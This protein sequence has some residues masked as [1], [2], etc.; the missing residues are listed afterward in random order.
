MDSNLVGCARK[1]HVTYA[2]DEPE[3]RDRLMAPA[4]A[5]TAWRC[6]RCGAF[7]TSGEHGIGPAAAAPLVRRGK[8][9][10]QR[11]DPARV[12]GGSVPPLP[13]HRRRGLRGVA[14]QVRPGRV[15]AGVRQRAA[16]HPRPVPGSR[17]QRQPLQPAQADQRVVRVRF[18][19]AHPAGHRAG[20]LRPH[21]TGGEHRAVAGQAVGRVLRHGGDL[22]LPAVG[23]LGPDQGAHH[24][25]EGRGARDQPVARHLPG[26]DQAAVRRPRRQGGL[27]SEAAQRVRHRGGAG[28]A[29]RGIARP[30]RPGHAR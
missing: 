18:A 6:L 12:R 13:G 30:A 17:L 22:D 20:S 1:G 9:A 4:S 28:R 29:R 26:V 3:L 14:V 25:A 10:A 24:L 16:G 19:L 15:P 5:G 21:R 23:G 27:R 7:V 11:A 8:G 2:P